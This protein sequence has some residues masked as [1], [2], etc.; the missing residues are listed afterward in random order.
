MNDL[1]TFLLDTSTII[2]T[3]YD[4]ATIE[5]GTRY[6]LSVNYLIF[7]A[8][9]LGLEGTFQI[10]AYEGTPLFTF[11][12][13]NTGEL[14]QYDVESKI[15][16]RS[17]SFGLNTLLDLSHLFGF[18]EKKSFIKKLD[19]DLELSLGMSFSKLSDYRYNPISN[20]E[21]NRIFHKSTDFYSTASI[22]VG[23]QLT[24]KN[25]FTHLGIKFGYQHLKTKPVMSEV[26][27]VIQF[28][29]FNFYRDTK[30]NFSGLFVGAYITLGK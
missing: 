24:S 6:K 23:Y 8:F 19:L 3:H 14:I 10:G 16:T 20:Q 13:P 25:L 1:N 22:N 17:F 27:T 7:P 12:H 29:G 26:G 5:N 30:L 11:I 15:Q 28:D 18:Q 2:P 21:E 9:R 4:S